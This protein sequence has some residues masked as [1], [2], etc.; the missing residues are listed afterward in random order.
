MGRQKG[1][2]RD[3]IAHQKKSQREQWRRQRLQSDFLAASGLGPVGMRCTME[4]FEARGG[5]TVKAK[6]AVERWA[7]RYARNQR[8]GEFTEGIFLY[9]GPGTGKTHL[10]CAAVNEVIVRHGL[11][12]FFVKVGEIPRADQNAVDSLASAALHP[13]LVLDDLGSEKLTPRMQEI[14][15]RVIDGRLWTQGATIVTS[16]LDLDQLSARFDEAEGAYPGWGRRLAGR[17]RE[18]C[19]PLRVDAEDRR[20]EARRG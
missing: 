12:A 15:L 19:V 20:M 1:P 9:G 8:A 6:A 16:N 13:L 17:I 14:A 11:P 7:A 10:A 5:N 2:S 3:E 18:L 4:S